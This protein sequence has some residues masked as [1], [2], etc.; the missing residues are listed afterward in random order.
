MPA[1]KGRELGVN[2]VLGCLGSWVNSI[3]LLLI[4][5]V[6]SVGLNSVVS[7]AK[8]GETVGWKI[9]SSFVFGWR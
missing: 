9:K 1:K 2:D 6:V 4:C 5:C 3:L 7:V 8:L